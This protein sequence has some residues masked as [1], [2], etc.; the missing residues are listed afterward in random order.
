MIRDRH[1]PLLFFGVIL[2]LATWLIA[3]ATEPAVTTHISIQPDNISLSARE[4]E[5]PSG[6]TLE[7]YS[8]AELESLVWQAE[9]DAPWLHLSPSWGTFNSGLSK[10]VVFMETSGISAGY[11][12]AT[13]SIVVQE[14]DNSPLIIPVQFNV[15]PPED[16]TVVAT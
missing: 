16:P 14:A 8:S 5:N 9:D 4:G 13:I 1:L 2:L 3:C 10:A 12:G 11:Y 15:L 7:I 6:E